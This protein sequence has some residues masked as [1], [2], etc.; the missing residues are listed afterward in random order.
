M[1][2]RPLLGGSGLGAGRLSLPRKKSEVEEQEAR[3]SAAVPSWMR[4]RRCIS[5]FLYGEAGLQRV[6]FGGGRGGRSELLA[7]LQGLQGFG[8]FVLFFEDDALQ[9]G[10]LGG[11]GTVFQAVNGL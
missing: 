1:A 9:G 11:I 5:G 10:G 8:Q 6:D 7:A 3:V 2:T 4:R